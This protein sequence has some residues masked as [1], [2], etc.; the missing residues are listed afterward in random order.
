MPG[1][2]LRRGEY[3]EMAHRLDARFGARAVFEFAD[4]PRLAAAEERMTAD[5]LRRRET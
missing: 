1:L 3:A 4:E 2:V 5:S